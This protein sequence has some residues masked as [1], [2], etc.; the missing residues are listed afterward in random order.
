MNLPTA[1]GLP[2]GNAAFKLVPADFVVHELMPVVPQGDGEH[3]WL[4]IEKT[5]WNTED[6]ALWLASAAG[7]HRL[8]V[9]YSGLKDKH[10][11]TRQ[12]FSIHLPGK[13]D[14]V[15]DCPEG[16]TLLA[17]QRHRRKLNRGTHRANHFDIRLQQVCAD[18]D[19]IDLRL[20]QIARLG[21]PNYFG[22]QRFGRGAGN[23]ERGK[24]WLAGQGEAPRKRALRGMWL[25]AVRSELFNRVLALRVE[26]GCWNTAIEGDVFQPANSRGLFHSA[27]DEDLLQRIERAEVH[28]TAPMPG[29]GGML[30]L[31]RAAALEQQ[32]LAENGAVIAGLEQQGVEH[33]R[34]ATR[35][36][37][38][39]LQWQ[40][41]DHALTLRMTLP[42]GG[43]A[44][45]VLAELLS[46]G[47]THNTESTTQQ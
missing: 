42:V 5:G 14:P 7:V 6:V 25:S 3:L 10:A 16:L 41:Q 22:P 36:M 17:A 12:W 9:G 43:F 47:T 40:W 11:I 34:R 45:V 1:H 29:A 30:P 46:T 27:L 21:V 26:Q 13:V 33:A 8:S 39:K 4:E 28:P 2:L 19:A 37:V 35:M 15:L 31:G 38:Q 18:R 44:T 32:A 23:S 24:Q 20:Q